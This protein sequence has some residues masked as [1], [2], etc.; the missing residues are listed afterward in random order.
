MSS[1]H[2]HQKCFESHE[3]GGLAFCLPRRNNNRQRAL[4]E[5]I[6]IQQPLL[7]L[8][9]PKPALEPQIQPMHNGSDPRTH[10]QHREV[11]PHA[12]LWAVREG[13]ERR[14]IR[15]HDTTTTTTNQHLIVMGAPFL[16]RQPPLRPECVW[17]GVEV[18]RVTL[19]SVR[20][21]G[22]RGAFWHKASPK[23]PVS[24]YKPLTE[25]KWEGETRLLRS[26]HLS[27]A[28]GLR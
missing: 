9:D 13:Y 2:A 25:E 22:D 12:V 6:P 14:R 21:H 5:D 15:H 19:E 28:A 16:M 27:T 17:C 7:P 11:L 1:A 3:L 23:H 24:Q 10:L 20:V 8:L 4:C 26:N 18:S